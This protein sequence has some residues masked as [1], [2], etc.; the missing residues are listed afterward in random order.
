MVK[1]IQAIRRQLADELF[2]LCFTILWGWRLKSQLE[3]LGSTPQFPIA[4]LF[5]F[6]FWKLWRVNL[7]I[8]A[9]RKLNI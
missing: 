4:E 8:S 1:H 6:L 9:V 2:E 5:S 3:A 7:H